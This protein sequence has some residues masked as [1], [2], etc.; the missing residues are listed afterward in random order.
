[1]VIVLL[2]IEK[3]FCSVVIGDFND[4]ILLV[5]PLGV[6]NTFRKLFSVA[7]LE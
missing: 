6:N 7:L 5:Y 2:Q 3:S 4:D 1:V